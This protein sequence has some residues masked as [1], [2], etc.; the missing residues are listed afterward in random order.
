MVIPSLTDD[1]A[2][3]KFGS[4]EVADVPSGKRYIRMTVRTED[5]CYNLKGHR[6]VCSL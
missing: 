2:T 6:P 3:E 1:A 4:F 5:R